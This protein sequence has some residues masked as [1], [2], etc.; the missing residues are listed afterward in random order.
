VRSVEKT[1]RTVEEAVEA[2]LSE[3]GL[4]KDDVTI[5]V[6]L[7]PSRGFLGLLGGKDARVRVTPKRDRA[8]MA[9]EFV[10]GLLERMGLEVAIEVRPRGEVLSLDIVG[11]DMGL[12]IGRHGE[13]LRALE[14]LTNLASGRGG[15]EVKRVLVD[16]SGY[17]KRRERELEEIAKALAR[18]VQRTGES[19]T[20]HP[21][22]A[23]DRRVIHVA[24][25]DDSSVSTHSE[26]EEPFRRVVVSPK[27]K[28][29]SPVQ[30]DT[31]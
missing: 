30:E 21:L 24:L 16:V 7:E 13:T 4:T 20:T 25:Q 5:E 15:G 8:D 23:R 17:R 3:M 2:A 10:A 27:D 19:A 29:E 28:Q 22:D 9:K 14:F 11:D 26:G 1:G 12:L 31:P 18:R 6:L